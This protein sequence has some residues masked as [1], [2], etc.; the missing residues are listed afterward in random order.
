[1]NY[2]T[3]YIA[4]HGIL[5]KLHIRPEFIEAFE[6]CSYALDGKTPATYLMIAGENVYEVRAKEVDAL[7]NP[8]AEPEQIFITSVT[9]SETQNSN[10]PLWRCYDEDGNQINFFDHE[11]KDKN[12]F[13]LLYDAGYA[14]HFAKMEV[15]ETL[16]W[17]DNPILVYYRWNGK[18]REPVRVA[19]R[20]VN[21]EPDWIEED[22]DATPSPFNL[23]KIKG[24]IDDIPFD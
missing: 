17:N 8:E 19:D 24:G 20:E 16:Y 23:D 4:E 6:V 2:K 13:T 14:T 3:F 7:L 22:E 5:R 10:S 21:E 1:M 18:W 11:D 15:D 12:T 9:R